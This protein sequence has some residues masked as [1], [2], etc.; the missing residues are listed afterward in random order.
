ML[1]RLSNPLEKNTIGSQ[2]YKNIKSNVKSKTTK[3][4]KNMFSYICNLG[5]YKA[6]FVDPKS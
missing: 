3:I 6:Y 1:G 4:D 2:S 5:G